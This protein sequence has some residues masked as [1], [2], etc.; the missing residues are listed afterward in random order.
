MRGH[1]ILCHEVRI[2]ACL[3]AVLTT[4]LI[5]LIVSGKLVWVDH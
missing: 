2:I 1:L 4:M 3:Q 5:V